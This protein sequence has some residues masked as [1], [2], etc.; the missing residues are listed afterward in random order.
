MLANISMTIMEMNKRYL[1]DKYIHGLN[2]TFEYHDKILLSLKNRDLD[3]ALKNLQIHLQ[4]GKETFLKII[5]NAANTPV[6][7]QAA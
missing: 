4:K 5:E 2:A 6:K 1:A 7:V 3:M